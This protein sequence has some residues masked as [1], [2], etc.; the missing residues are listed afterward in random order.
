MKGAA[1]RLLLEAGAVAAN[2]KSETYRAASAR[3]VAQIAIGEL[4]CD[5]AALTGLLVAIREGVI[6]L[7]LIDGAPA[8]QHLACGLRSMVEAA[9]TRKHSSSVSRK[10]VSAARC[11]WA[12]A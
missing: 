5:D 12:E 3:E 9:R 8:R 11:W 10:E 4:T 6:A 7:A 1:M 2:H